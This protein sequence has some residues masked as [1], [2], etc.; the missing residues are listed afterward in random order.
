MTI[1]FTN[2]ELNERV[3]AIILEGSLSYD[4]LVRKEML[5]VRIYG[6]YNQTVDRN[7][8]NSITELRNEG[9]PIISTSGKAGYYYDENSIDAIIADYSSRIAQMSRTIKALRRGRKDKEMVQ[10]GFMK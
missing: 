9:Y 6:Y 1:R 3:L 10:M 5:A 7:I 4:R 8:R 2:D